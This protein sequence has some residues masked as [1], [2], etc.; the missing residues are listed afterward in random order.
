MDDG[1]LFVIVV[2]IMLT[3]FADSWDMNVHTD[4][5]ISQCQ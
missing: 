4:I 5:T 3:L 2:K 1:E